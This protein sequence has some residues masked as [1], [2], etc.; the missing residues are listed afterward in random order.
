MSYVLY[1][2]Y[3][4]KLTNKAYVHANDGETK[5]A[6]RVVVKSTTLI[7]AEHDM[8]RRQIVRGI[9]DALRS[10]SFTNFGVENTEVHIERWEGDRAD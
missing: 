8:V 3:V 4:K 7:E 6:I 10:A 5:V 9:A 2:R 1:A